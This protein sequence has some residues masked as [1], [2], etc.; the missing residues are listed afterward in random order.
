MFARSSGGRFSVRM[1]DLDTVVSRRELADQQLRD[2]ASVGIDWDGEV[3]FQSARTEL[4]REAVSRLMEADRTYPCF[5]TRREIRDAASAPNGQPL[6]D[7][8]YPGTC[9]HLTAHQ[10][11]ELIDAGRRPAQRVRADECVV[12]IVDDV[13]GVVE[14]TVDDFVI[15][16]NDGVF[17]YNLA[18][19]V[20]DA[21]QDIRQVVRADDLLLSSPRQRWLGQQL[22]LPSVRYA[23]VPLVLGPDGQRLAKR[24]GAVS[25]VDLRS[26]G[27]SADAVR[28]LLLQ[29]LG[30]AE[31]GEV[32]GASDLLSRFASLVIERDAWR[33]S[34][35]DLT[36]IRV[37][38]R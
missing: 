19:V 37:P 10:R 16:R 21:A 3:V 28:S 1:E 35:D 14:A 29:N 25:L 7:G 11:R 23:H 5:C 17:A 32:V 20:D 30:L 22:G 9:R 15:V 18:V 38:P 26:H 36:A 13:C 12:T 24:H 33:L 34:S 6:P 2:L 8:A 4:Y 27:W 31:Y